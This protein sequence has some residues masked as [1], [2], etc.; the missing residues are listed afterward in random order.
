MKQPPQPSDMLKAIVPDLHRIHGDLKQTQPGHLLQY[1]AQI[2]RLLLA[3]TK[4]ALNP[5]Q[6]SF[7]QKTLTELRLENAKL[8]QEL[9]PEH[10]HECFANPDYTTSLFGQETGSLL[11]CLY[12]EFRRGTEFA[13]KQDFQ[14]LYMLCQFF[15]RLDQ[16]AP[17]NADTVLARY[18]AYKDETLVFEEESAVYEETASD[19]YDR[20]LLESDLCD[21]RYLYRYGKYVTDEDVHLAEFLNNYPPDQLDDM[22]RV[23]VDALLHGFISQNRARRERAQVNFIYQMGQEQLAR[24]VV[25]EFQNRGITA[26]VVQVGALENFRQYEYDH[27]FDETLY[28][29]EAYLTKSLEHYQD[30]C[31]KHEQRLRGICGRVEIIQFGRLPAILQEK[32]TALTLT[33]PQNRLKKEYTLAKKN[34]S[35]HYISPSDI[36]FCK[37]GFPNPAI[38]QDFETIFQAFV[39]LNLADSRKF[40]V[41]QQ[42]LIDALD[43]ADYVQVKG[44]DG[45]ETDITI[46]MNPLKNRQTQTNFL[47]CGG[48]LN[49]PHGEVFTTP[50]LKGTHGLLHVKDIYLK[51]IRYLDLRL[52]FQDGIIDRFSCQNF[53]EEEQN[54]HYILNTLFFPHSTLPM[55]EFAIGTNTLAYMIAKKYHL[56]ASLPILLLEKMGPH[57]AIGDPCYAWGEEQ[58]IFN[59]LDGK[60]VVA[61]ENEK[62]GRRHAEPERAYTNIHIDITLPYDEIAFVRAVQQDGRQLDIIRNGRFVLEGVEE[63]NAPFDTSI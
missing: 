46:A 29:D 34:I 59:L 39:Q 24:R 53:G 4:F 9:S 38:G 13:S 12:H 35:H 23:I 56:T 1:H 7:A 16:S 43:L 57:F 49:I 52:H 3:V 32:D 22:A 18:K 28:L 21:L 6:E 41:Y 62:T 14:R 48:D 33:A 31:A 54:K 51:G 10:Y 47:N 50:V 36:S 42:T 19:F 30:I 44:K 26:H 15:T 27:R 20:I 5:K 61:K 63:L 60:E 11:A 40:E 55:G 45:N 25:I 8:Y 17:I 37:V 2:C 58:P